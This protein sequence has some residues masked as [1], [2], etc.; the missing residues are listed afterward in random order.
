[1]GLAWWAL[2]FPF[3]RRHSEE[4]LKQHPEMRSKDQETTRKA[5]EKFAF[6]THQRDEPLRVL[7]SR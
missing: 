2:E 1:M 4:F 5:C 6:D 7:D 3:M